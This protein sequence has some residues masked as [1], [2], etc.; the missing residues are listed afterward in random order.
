MVMRFCKAGVDGV[1]KATKTAKLLGTG[2]TAGRRRATKIMKDRLLKVKEA[3]PA[4]QALRKLGLSAIDYMRTAEIPQ[5][6]YGCD[7]MGMSDTMLHEAVKVS[8]ALVAPPN[9]G[10]NP[11]L[12]MHAM[13]VH[14][15]AVDPRIIGNTSP[16]ASW[17]LAW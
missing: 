14:S 9:A 8:S 11:R 4:V 17:A 12:V 15:E 5:M 16:I 2:Y 3:V 10:K 7:T 6:M 13:K 1:L